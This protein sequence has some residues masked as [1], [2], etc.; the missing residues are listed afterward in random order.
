MIQLTS[1]L[2]Q[3]VMMFRSPAPDCRIALESLIVCCLHAGLSFL[4][5]YP[6]SVDRCYGL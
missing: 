4:H 1:G 3:V 5:R 6:A 2:Q